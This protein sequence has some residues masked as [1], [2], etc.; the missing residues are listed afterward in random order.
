MKQ[1]EIIKTYGTDYTRMTVELLNAADL[2]GDII[3]KSAISC[4]N[5]RIGIKPNLVSCTPASYGAT[6]HPEI[7]RGIIEYLHAHDFRNIKIIEGSWVGDKTSD[8]FEYCG[9]N[10]LSKDLNVPITDT[11]TDTFHEVDCGGMMLNI[12]DSVDSIDYLINVPVLKGHCQTKITCALKNMKGLIP[13]SEKRRFHTLMLHKPI[14][15]LNLGIHQDFIVIDNI[16]GDPDFEEGGNPLVRNCI[17]VAKDPVLTD[18]YVCKIFELDIDEVP[19]VKIAGEIGVGCSDISKLELKYLGS[20]PDNDSPLPLSHKMLS[21]SYAIDDVNSCS[22]CY[23][24]L[25]EALNRLTD[26]GLLSDNLPKI[27][28]GQGYKGKSGEYGV[29]ACTSRFKHNVPGCP[30]DSESIYEHIKSWIGKI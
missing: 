1:N 30:P 16:C 27:C 15:H 26:E 10:E 7:V 3:Q 25:A 13:N 11:Q 28:I 18:A 14:A 5:I 19:Y 4:S 9:Y 21:V 22:A 2:A 24:G 8:A 6:T 17:M 20:S 12:C 29:G 23:A